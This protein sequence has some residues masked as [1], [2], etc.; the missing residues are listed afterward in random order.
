MARRMDKIGTEF[1]SPVKVGKDILSS[2]GVGGEK[3]WP[4]EDTGGEE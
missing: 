4:W 1:R 3:R 2:S